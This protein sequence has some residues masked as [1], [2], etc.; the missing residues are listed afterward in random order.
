MARI[1]L[2]EPYFGGSHRSWAEGFQRHSSHEVHLVTHDGNFWRWRLRGSSVTLAQETALLCAE[3]GKPDVLLVSD[4]VNLP[5][6]LGLVRRA[7]GD[8]EVLLYLHENQLSY[9]LGPQQQPDEALALVNWVSMVAADRI[10]VNS[11]FHRRELFAE[12]PKLLKRAPDLSHAD[13]LDGVSDRTSVLPV[14]I[15]LSDIASPSNERTLDADGPLVLWSHR[16]DH[17]KNPKAVFASLKK[18][19]DR[20]VPFR[21]A[22]AGENERVDPREFLEAQEEFADRITHVGFLDRPDYCALLTQT[23][24]VVSAAHHEFFGIA[25]IEAMTA[26]A[27]PVLPDRLSY[28]EIVPKRFHSAALYADAEL[29]TRLEQVL[30]NLESTRAAVEGLA[31]ELRVH[32]WEVVAPTYDKELTPEIFARS[33]LDGGQAR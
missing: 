15:E 26:G 8:P 5:A 3:V 6:F 16:W 25:M 24:V 31:D 1:F 17:D 14:G 4:F 32:D 13:L 23:D 22:I 9:P 11:E 29:T 27:V 2:I 7:V 10:F 30:L 21:L 20:G 28:P 33:H 12:L 19:R 18:L